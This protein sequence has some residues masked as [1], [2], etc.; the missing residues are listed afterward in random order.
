MVQPEVKMNDIKQTPPR[1]RTEFLLC[2]IS[3]NLTQILGNAVSLN[4]QIVLA[5]AVSLGP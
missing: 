3:E 4:F 2:E 1:H 5:R